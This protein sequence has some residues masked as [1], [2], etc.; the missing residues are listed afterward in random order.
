MLHEDEDEKPDLLHEDDLVR[1]E[2]GAA[3]Q[4]AATWQVRTLL[5][6]T[7]AKLF[8][9]ASGQSVKETVD[10]S[11][12]GRCYRLPADIHILNTM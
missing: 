3:G 2:A 1:R 9:C 6:A 7:C 11:Q 8:K 4:L 12:W 10:R 5:F